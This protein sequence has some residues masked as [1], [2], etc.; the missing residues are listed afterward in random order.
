MLPTHQNV[1]P[2]SGG[3]GVSASAG[4]EET[5]LP[6]SIPTSGQTR[7]HVKSVQS[8]HQLSIF[9]FLLP[10]KPAAQLLRSAFAPA[11]ALKPRLLHDPGAHKKTLWPKAPVTLRGERT[12]GRCSIPL[13]VHT[14][15][16]ADKG[17]VSI[18]ASCWNAHHGYAVAT[19]LPRKNR[20]NQHRAGERKGGGVQHKIKMSPKLSILGVPWKGV[21]EGPRGRG[22]SRGGDGGSCTGRGGSARP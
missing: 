11:T 17:P 9:G 20:K 6:V 14:A 21:R 22:D 10:P 4:L 15:C 19:T 13:A 16:L 18:Q 5:M 3:E 12:D 8:S 1:I 7:N 2:Q